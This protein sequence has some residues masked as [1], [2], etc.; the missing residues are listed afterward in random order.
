MR[1][2]NVPL[3]STWTLKGGMASTASIRMAQPSPSLGSCCIAT[4]FGTGPYAAEMM[5]PKGSVWTMAQPAA[6]RRGSLGSKQDPSVKRV[7][8]RSPSVGR[9]SQYTSP[10][11]SVSGLCASKPTGS[12]N[13][14]IVK[15]SAN[16]GLIF[17]T[18]LA[19]RRSSL[20]AFCL[21][22]A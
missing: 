4:A 21:R 5:P 9:L 6:R 1:H 18:K 17:R 13:K 7:P 11:P 15:A 10:S 14:P 3:Q 22:T 8:V 16:R 20:E 12:G 19:A 2:L